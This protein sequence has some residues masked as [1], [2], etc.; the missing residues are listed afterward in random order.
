[1]HKSW[2]YAR[3]A[4][5][6]HV[7]MYLSIYIYISIY[8]YMYD[9]ICMPPVC[10]TLPTS[11]CLLY[12]N[13]HAWIDAWVMSCLSICN[14][15]ST[16]GCASKD[17]WEF[18]GLQWRSGREASPQPT[19]SVVDLAWPAELGENSDL[20]DLPP[21]RSRSLEHVGTLRYQ[22]MIWWW[23]VLSANQENVPRL[24]GPFFESTME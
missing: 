17:T 5:T 16:Q 18:K 2:P 1:M 15:Y 4:F 14:S 23:K 8:M 19:S 12:I 3:T 13:I 10:V 11:I 21:N 22:K 9:H 24:E 6:L 7:F 20:P